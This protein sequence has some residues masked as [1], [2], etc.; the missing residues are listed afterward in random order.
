GRKIGPERAACLISIASTGPDESQV[1]REPGPPAA[2]F[3]PR[4]GAGTKAGPEPTRRTRTQWGGHHDKT[5]YRRGPD[6][7]R[8]RRRRP[9][10][11]HAEDRRDPALFGP[12]RRYRHPG[13]P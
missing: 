9:S 12:V 3:R 5:A 2:G 6:R 10:G 11:G 7:G 1:D 13:R 8:S 4:T